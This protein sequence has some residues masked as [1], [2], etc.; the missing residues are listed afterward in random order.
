MRRTLACKAGGSKHCLTPQELKTVQTFATE[1]HTDQLL[2]HGC[3]GDAGVSTCWRVR[4]LRGSMGLLHHA[5]HPP[6]ILLNS[7]YYVVG[8]QVLRFFVTGD[9]HYDA[10]TFDTVTG[11]GVCERSAAAVA[12]LRRERSGSATVCEAW[13]EVPDATWDGGCDDPDGCLGTLLP[14]GAER[15]DAGGDGRLSAV[16]TWCRGLG[17]GTACS[18]LVSTRWACW[19]SGWMERRQSGLRW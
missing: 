3:D 10:L 8:D 11:G 12:G 4:I 19:I 16:S 2:A 18:T 17:M 7:F 13:R 1:Q 15:D 9:P 5:E 6:R 14:D